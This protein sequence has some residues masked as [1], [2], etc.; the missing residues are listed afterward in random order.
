MKLKVLIP[1]EEYKNYAGARIRYARLAPQLERNGV[2]LTLDDIGT[3]VPEENEADA[4]LISKCHDA[5]ALVAAA[6]AYERGRLVGVDLFDDYFS[7]TGDSRLNRYRL[8]LRQ[9][10]K[11]CHFALCSTPAMAEVV[12]SYRPGLPVHI[13]NDP[14][15]HANEAELR[16]VLAAKLARARNELKLRIAWFGV[17]D[18]PHFRVGLSDL[19][20]Y[21]YMLKELAGSELDVEVAV[22]TNA[23]ALTAD[24]L[25]MI[26]KIPARVHV[27]E[28]TVDR[29]REV[30]SDAFA[31]FLPV[32]A[33]RFS[34]AKS[35]NRAI[36]ALSAG[37]QVISAGYPLYAPLG[38]LI[39]RDTSS[40]LSDVRHGSMRHSAA[41]LHNYDMV[42]EEFA[43]ALNEADRLAEFLRRLEPTPSDELGPIILV[44]GHATN[45]VAHKSVRALRGLSVGSPFCASELGFDVIFR[46]TGEGLAMLISDQAAK[47][48][49]AAERQSLRA[50]AGP[51][52]RKF[53]IVPENERRVS[54]SDDKPA[55]GWENAPLLF[56]RSAYGSTMAHIAERLRQ[57]F[58]PCRVF[59]SESSPLP[60]DAQF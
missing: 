54:D 50:A 5:R 24:G 44:H 29:E 32:S 23:R 56:H 45:G 31:C 41:R 55:F 59:I 34:A 14:A 3:F 33:Q 58:G 10:L 4:L 17:G 1:S 9:L 6:A 12:Q 46:P 43:S 18:N 7:Q 35:L 25:A 49:S 16:E 30:L 37:C 38:D 53:W 26:R 39:Y 36:T 42:V 21:G 51:S 27:Q 60:F 8:W 11:T 28:W 20:A 13:V 48:L 2:A 19:Y 52:E 15:P 22:L 47:R 40:L 57:A